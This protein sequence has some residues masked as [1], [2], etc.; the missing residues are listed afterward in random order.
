LEYLIKKLENL[1]AENKKLRAKGKKATTYSSSS[2]DDD[3]DEEIIKK[4]RKGRNKHDKTSY[5][6][7]SFNYNNM[8]SSITYTSVPIGKAPRFSG[9]NY[10]QWKHCMRNYLYSISPEV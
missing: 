9:S 2:E 1:K 5:N 6:I 8:S 3:S 10:N 4:R 7:M